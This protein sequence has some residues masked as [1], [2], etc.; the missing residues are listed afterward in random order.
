V[1]VGCEMTREDVDEQYSKPACEQEQEWVRSLV[2]VARPVTAQE[3][4]RALGALFDRW[5]PTA[6]SPWSHYAPDDHAE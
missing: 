1:E 5:F 3:S 2:G 6:G 4:E